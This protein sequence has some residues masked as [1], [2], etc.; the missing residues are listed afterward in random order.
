M[1]RAIARGP[2]GRP[3]AIASGAGRIDPREHSFQANEFTTLSWRP[4]TIARW[5]KTD[6]VQREYK[7][8]K[9][10][11][12]ENGRVL[13]APSR[14]VSL[15]ALPSPKRGVVAQ[16]A[17]A[18]GGALSSCIPLIRPRAIRIVNSMYGQSPG[19]H[20]IEQPMDGFCSAR[21]TPI[22]ATDRMASSNTR[23]A[24]A[25][26]GLVR[27]SSKRPWYCSRRFAS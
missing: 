5:P 16:S 21:A 22:D 14:S 7:L 12:I 15:P 6:L 3:R 4:R 10:A 19:F 11:R 27:P 9:H 26:G 24:L 8:Q 2:T 1:K 23:G 18:R 25:E 13:I 17:P 20:L